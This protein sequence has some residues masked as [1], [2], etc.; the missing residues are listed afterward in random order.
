MKRVTVNQEALENLFKVLSNSA[1]D[2]GKIDIL[3]TAKDFCGIWLEALDPKDYGVKFHLPNDIGEDCS[4]YQREYNDKIDPSIK[5]IDLANPSDHT[6]SILIRNE[7]TIYL[8]NPAEVFD[9]EEEG[10]NGK[11][12]F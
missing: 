1:D 6:P 10:H 7:R 4:F 2:N 11:W 3:A 12:K 5:R 9:L 8:T